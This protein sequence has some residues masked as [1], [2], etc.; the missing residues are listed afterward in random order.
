MIRS[1][2]LSTL[3]LAAALTPWPA[4]TW[5]QGATAQTGEDWRVESLRDAVIP[6]RSLLPT[7]T[8]FPDLEPLLPSLARVRVLILGEATHGDGTTF[9]A[10]ARLIRFL[11]TRADFNT[12]AFETGMFSLERGMSGAR[13][14]DAAMAGLTSS[15]FGI[16]S[17]S[18]QALPALQYVGRTAGTGSPL[19]VVGMDAQLA[20]GDTVLIH[21]LQ[22]FLRAADYPRSGRFDRAARTLTRLVAG[23]VLDR[24]WPLERLRFRHEMESMRGWLAERTDPESA[25]WLLFT[26]NA[27]AYVETAWRRDMAPREAQMAANLEHLLER[28]PNARIIVWAAS[29]Y[30]ITAAGTIEDADGR[31]PYRGVLSAGEQLRDRIGHE[32][33]YTLAFTA[34]G[35]EYGTWNWSPPVRDLR[36]ASAGS[37]EAIFAA[38]GFEHA[39]LDFHQLPDHAAWVGEPL[40][41]RPLGYTEMRAR[42][43]A[44]VDGFFLILA[45]RPSTRTAAP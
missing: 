43:P 15:V 28:D 34:S 44:V 27:R 42:W 3:A 19:R 21:Q 18:E 38:T 32:A 2:R 17:R 13:T 5:V 24:A 25:R 12:L 37:L 30:G 22:Q 9:E 16:W 4:G 36:P 6:V 41:A 45:M 23:S 20:R 29:I 7:D 11:H 14:P 10:R 39:I 33:V 35:G 40:V 26:D 1:A 8:L 31:A